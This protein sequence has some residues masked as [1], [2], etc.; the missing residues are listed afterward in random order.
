MNYCEK[1]AAM[2]LRLLRMICCSV[3][4]FSASLQGHLYIIDINDTVTVK[5]DID[6]QKTRGVVVG[7]LVAQNICLISGQPV[8]DHIKES[9]KNKSEQRATYAR[10]TDYIQKLIDQKLMT[11]EQLNDAEML[12]ARY[13]AALQVCDK[14]TSAIF[15]SLLRLIKYIEAYDPSPR[16][17]FQSFGAEIPDLL[18]FLQER[19]KGGPWSVD[20]QIGVFDDQGMF[21]WKGMS[22]DS[23]CYEALNPFEDEKLFP[24]F[25][26]K[27]WRNNYTAW[28]NK[29]LQIGKLIFCD[30]AGP[31]QTFFFDDKAAICATLVVGDKI[32]SLPIEKDRIDGLDLN[33]LHIVNVDTARALLDKNYF[34]TIVLKEQLCLKDVRNANLPWDQQKYQQED[35]LIDVNNRSVG[36]G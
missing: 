2:L 29:K 7:Q 30:K 20:H 10:L 35:F 23:D 26:I 27:A 14:Q 8:E 24:R 25:S 15:P 11:I 22:F 36:E 4:F 33:C 19:L 16:I 5:N 6:P 17:L 9:M 18:M 34:A 28:K 1:E 31:D 3:V 21:F 32:F 12:K 13:A